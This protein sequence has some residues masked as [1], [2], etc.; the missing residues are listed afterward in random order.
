VA[1]DKFKPSKSFYIILSTVFTL[2]AF[3]HFD[4]LSVLGIY[5]SKI[6]T[7]FSLMYKIVYYTS[8]ALSEEA[9]FNFYD[10]FY[11]LIFILLVI[12]SKRLSIFH[13]LGFTFIFFNLLFPMTNIIIFRLRYYLSIGF[14]YLLIKDFKFKENIN[15]IKLPAMY[16]F[17]LLFYAKIYILEPEGRDFI[18]P[19]DNYIISKIEY[20]CEDPYKMNDMRWAGK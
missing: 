6:N 16:C 4:I 17:C 5:L 8:E 1:L 20:P 2:L 18:N 10:I 14:I 19:Y 11:V 15:L 9:K 3:F 7:S 12:M 13:A